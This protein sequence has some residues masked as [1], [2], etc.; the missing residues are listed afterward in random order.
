VAEILSVLQSVG[1][2]HEQ[3]KEKYRWLGS[4]SI[5]SSLTKLSKVLINS[6]RNTFELN[7]VMIVF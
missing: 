5:I 7:Y 1:V 3:G 2:V 6:K 4:S